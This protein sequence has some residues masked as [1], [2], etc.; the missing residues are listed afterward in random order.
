MEKC[1]FCKGIIENSVTNYMLD[2]NGQFII[3]NVPCHKC[4]QCGEVSFSYQT[5]KQLEKIV[6]N[7]KQALTEVAIVE[8]A[9]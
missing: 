2:L 8:Y 4:S 6:A 5:M 3:K 9:A 7:L 1:F